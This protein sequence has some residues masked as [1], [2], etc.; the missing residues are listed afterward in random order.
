M[1][2]YPSNI[3]NAPS[4][5]LPGL[6]GLGLF[7]VVPFLPGGRAVAAVTSPV[8]TTVTAPTTAPTTA[9][10][11]EEADDAD[12]EQVTGVAEGLGKGLS[13]RVGERL[14]SRWDRK[15][16]G[17][18]AQAGAGERHPERRDP[19]EQEWEE[20]VVF[21]EAHAPRRLEMYE[22]FVEWIEKRKGSQSPP[23]RTGGEERIGRGPEGIIRIARSRMFHRVDSLRHLEEAD[24]ELYTFALR[25]F[26][27]EDEIYAAMSDVREARASEDTAA[28]EEA[29]ERAHEVIRRYAQ[30]S[31]AERESRIERL[32]EEL[33]REQERLQRDR[34]NLDDVVRR[35]EKRFSEAMPPERGKPRRERR[36]GGWHREDDGTPGAPDV[37]PGQ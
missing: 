21:L 24:P 20:T 30:N 27:L 18:A 28:L 29:E 2:P 36:D 6:I 26:E 15:R 4:L 12:D 5:C 32:R 1:K 33:E 7:V 11:A 22:N 35:L 13:S 3:R 10:S 34:E 14:R 19:S 31:F 17:K 16:N 9:P 37:E 8:V 23:T 25:Q